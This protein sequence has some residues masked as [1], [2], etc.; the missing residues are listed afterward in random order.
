MVEVEQILAC[1]AARIMLRPNPGH[2]T[3]AVDEL[4]DAVYLAARRIA[5]LI[6]RARAAGHAARLPPDVRGRELKKIAD[7]AAAGV[8]CPSIDAAA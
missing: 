7:A 3:E 4:A 1:L 8:P 5:A 6:A 2:Y